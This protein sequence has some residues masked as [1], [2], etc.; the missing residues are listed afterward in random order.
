MS[1][2]I[3]VAFA[4]LYA[5]LFFAEPATAQRVAFKD[6][7]IRFNT[8]D[9]KQVESSASLIFDDTSRRV[10]VESGQKPVQINYDDVAQVI[11]D[12]RLRIHRRGMA[13]EIGLGTLTD[14]YRKLGGRGAESIGR[15]IDNRL[16]ATAINELTDRVMIIQ[17][18][19]PGSMLQFVIE[20]G[21][22]DVKQV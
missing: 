18:N 11:F 17:T 15:T 20:I 19:A 14:V 7:R 6:V 9:R 10:L 3:M 2:S 1:K 8:N 22:D 4:S 21:I 13:K 16:D 5:V 12:W